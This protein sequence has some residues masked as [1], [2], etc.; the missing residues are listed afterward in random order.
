MNVPGR[1]RSAAPYH[2]AYGAARAPLGA[3]AALGAARP[4]AAD[5]ATTAVGVRGLPTILQLRLNELREARLVDLASAGGYAL[6][7]LGLEL[8]DAFLPLYAFADR[9]R[10]IRKDDLPA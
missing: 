6:T 3:E 9:W 2:G 5:L 7:D 4:A 1:R 10:L 8:I